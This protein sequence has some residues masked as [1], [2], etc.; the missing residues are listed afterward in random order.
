MGWFGWVAGIWGVLLASGCSGDAGAGR[1]PPEAAAQRADAGAGGGAPIRLRLTNWNVKNFFDDRVDN[2][3]VGPPCASEAPPDLLCEDVP[4]SEA[5]QAK[6]SAL[7]GVLA[8]LDPDVIVLPET[9]SWVGASALAARLGGRSHVVVSEG[10]DP[11]GIEIAVISRWPLDRVVS[12][13]AES[14]D[15][16]GRSYRFARD[17][18]EV[19]LT[20]NGRHLVL[21]GVHFKASDDAASRAKRVAEAT[22]VRSIAASLMR[23][24]PSVAIVV[25]GDF[26][27]TPASEPIA[28]LLGA[29]PTRFYS[30]AELVPEAA[31]TSYD[32][33][34]LL[35]DQISNAALYDLVRVDSASI[36]H[37][38]GV[39]AA[40]DHEPLT[41]DYAVE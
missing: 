33:R 30:A 11:R 41:V 25:L 8:P 13:A 18:L 9:E 38:P 10:N 12:H 16:A 3:T 4:S 36:V 5:Y 22:Q 39:A 29:E 23:A 1:E 37:G 21:L 32:D 14:F 24:D 15:G 7:A 20:L 2:P 6:V 40:S 35:D 31:R 34:V 28:V 27:A 26:N 19:H 17:C